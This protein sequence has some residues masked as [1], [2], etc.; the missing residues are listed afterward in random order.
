MRKFSLFILLLLTACSQSSYTGISPLIEMT[1]ITGRPD[2]GAV[3]RLLQTYHD[4]DI[5][6]MLIY[7]RS[8]LE[9]EYMSDEWMQFCRNCVEVA[10]SL[11]MRIWLYDEYNWPSGNCKGQVTADGHEDLYPALMLF[12]N[13]GS[14]T[15]THR[16]V[17][18]QLGAD[19][20]NPDAVARFIA[21][22]HQRYYDE[23][24]EYFGTVIPAIFTDEPSFSYSTSRNGM[25]E[26]NFTNFDNDH[27]ALAWYEG[28][29]ED[30]AAASGR[31]FCDDVV[32]YLHGAESGTLW[33]T[34]YSIVGDRMR[35]VYV[36]TLSRWC[37]EHGIHL[38]GHLQY[39][40]LYKSVRCNGNIL[41]MLSQFGIPGFDEANSD[42]DINAREME[43]S[44][45]S[46]VQYA[47]RGKTGEIC[48]LFSVGPGDLTLSIQRQLMWMCSA[49]GVNN[50][51]VAVSAMDARG[52]KEKNDW[53]Y[54]SG[55]TQPW[56]D[57]YR[58]FA[59]EARKAA[60]YARKRYEPSVLVRVPSTWF[61]SLDKTP[62][63]EVE[64]LKY[65]RFL[66]ALLQHQVQY[67]LLDEDETGQPGLPVLCFG[68]DGFYVEGETQFYADVHA[69]MDHVNIITPREV[70]VYD[71][72]GAE[73]RDVLVR[74][75]ADGTMTLVD[76]TDNDSSD[77]LLKV[78]GGRR[79]GTVRLAGHGAFAGGFEEMDMSQPGL[80][81]PAEFKAP[82]M[83]MD[84]ANLLRC[85]YT[86]A[87]RSFAFAVEAPVDVRVLARQAVDALT[88]TLDGHDV[89]ICEPVDALPFGFR[90]LFGASSVIRLEAG[91]HVLS[92]VDG[93]PDYR[94]LPG[95]YLA[96]EFS[97]CDAILA[98][99]DGAG[100]I[101]SR[102]GL[103][104]YAGTYEV[105]SPVDIP[106]SEGTVLALN[107]NL[108]C[109]EVLIDG[110]SLG[111]RAWA[112]YEWDIPSEYLG[113]THDVTV[114]IS[115]SVMSMFG[116]IGRLEAEQPYVDWLRIK[117]GQ[118]G[119]KSTT[120]IFDA[121]WL[122][123]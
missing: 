88:V 13:D 74:S 44:G 54:S 25:L 99:W 72:T 26:S 23:F 14:G 16:I 60:E 37:E 36:G 47:G 76:L 123:R 95:L 11:G 103:E 80:M 2:R 3:T 35:S 48:E 115:T 8:G 18:N 49:F 33:S 122:R 102:D 63:F 1:A 32:A 117:P 120:G 100:R 101:T 9:I 98:P 112:P 65:L 119:D 21:L 84:G 62:A 6:Q 46:L 53:Y 86:Q 29:E 109:T 75:W 110:K 40:K 77:R 104:G 7:P 52:N 64:G 121:L 108:S 10:D 113:G 111:K 57:Y 87:D 106:S 70:V 83:S 91:E 15:Y 27:F 69:Y 90:E 97:V 61:M 118:H 94:F 24:S 78:R 73:V 20:L 45:L 38:T 12:D 114:R 56:F 71:E 66:E 85:I 43:I 5:D 19:I 93:G 50:Y 17:H 81:I 58:E 34:Y 68:P 39:E 82:V 89:E 41:K 105:T 22:T 42:I 4:A 31:D 96:G 30:Y 51:L 67:M 55:P 59:S 107:T 28:L 79:S 116:N 92:V